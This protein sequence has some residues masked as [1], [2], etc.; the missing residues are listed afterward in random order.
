[1]DGL[2]N[3]YEEICMKTETLMTYH[4][5]TCEIDMSKK[6]INGKHPLKPPVRIARTHEPTANDPGQPIEW[7]V[8]PSD[9]KPA[10]FFTS[11]IDPDAVELP[12][13]ANKRP[14]LVILFR[15]KRGPGEPEAE[16]IEIAVVWR[17]KQ[18]GREKGGVFNE[19]KISPK[20]LK[21]GDYFLK[22]PIYQTK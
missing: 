3:P 9:L 6:D 1:M 18:P 20:G 22:T 16:P 7:F 8:D 21:K 13:I 11:P 12:D 19:W 10:V 14:I 4:I 17:R 15:E 5:T 2:T